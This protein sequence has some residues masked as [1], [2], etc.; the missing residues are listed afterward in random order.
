MKR[1]R[2]LLSVLLA[3]VM[4]LPCFAMPIWAEEPAPIVNLLDTTG[5]VLGNVPKK[6]TSAARANASYCSSGVFTVSPGQTVTVGPVMVDQGYVLRTYKSDGEVLSD[7][8]PASAVSVETIFN[9]VAILTFTVP[10]NAVKAAIVTSR[11]FYDCALVTVDRTYTKAEYLAYMAEKGVNLDFL[12][13]AVD[14]TEA[15]VNLF[16][17]SENT[18]M[19]NMSAGTGKT[20]YRYRSCPFI[21]VTEGD[22]I[23]YA[24]ASNAQQYHIS[25]MTSGG[26][27]ANL[28]SPK[29][30]VEDLG[31]EFGIYAYRVGPDITKVSVV[32]GTPTYDDGITLVTK[33]QPFTAERY[34]EMFN[35]DFSEDTADKSSPLYGLSGL[36]MGDSISF[37]HSDILSYLDDPACGKAWAGRIAAA[38]GLRAT[39]A[40]VIGATV[41]YGSN[42]VADQYAD[43]VGKSFDLIVM[44]GGANDALK[45]TAVGTPL[46][47]GASAEELEA[48]TDTYIGGLQWLFHNMKE[49]FPKAE[50][51]FIANH[52]LDGNEYAGR[53]DM[54]AYFDA[55]E[56]LCETYGVHFIDLYNNDELN[57]RLETTTTKYLPDTTHLV[58]A[59]Y[60]IL[61]PYILEELEAEMAS[62]AKHVLYEEDFDDVS[63][64]VDLDGGNN[65]TGPAAGWIWARKSLA[66]SAYIENGRLYFSGKAY[67]VLYR[68]GGETWGNYTLEA[69]FCYTEGTV[70]W[71]GM[72]YNVQSATKFQKGSINPDGKYYLNGYDGGW[73][74]DKKNVNKGFTLAENIPGIGDPFRM[75]I[76][77]FNK[78]ATFYYALLNEDGTMKTDWTTL[79]TINNIPAASQTGSIGF[80]SCK[81]NLGSFWVD[82]I[83]CYSNNLVS[84]TEDFDSYG[85]VT[86]EPDTTNTSIGVNYVKNSADSFVGK[87]E[88]KDGAL[89]L[90]GGTKHL[91][92]FLFTMGKNW[93]NYVLES[94]FTYLD[95]I[96]GSNNSGWAGILFRATDT[97]TFYKC[98]VNKTGSAKMN[99]KNGSTSWYL[100]G[101]ERRNASYGKDIAVGETIR[102]RFVV[103][104]K[105]FSM[106]VA[107]YVDGVLGEWVHV[108]TLEGD[109]LITD[110]HLK[111]T[112]GLVVGGSN[113]AKACNVCIDNV[114]VSRI[115]DADRY[116]T[117]TTNVA[118]IYE[119][120]SGVVNPPV[121][122]EELTDT[123]PSTSGERA[124]VVMMNVD[125]SLN[126]L[127]AD[128]AVLTT[129]SDFIDTYRKVLIPAF[130]IDSEAEAD[131][132]AAL[133][134]EKNLIDCYV[135]AESANAALVRRVRMANDTTKL[136]SGAV[137]FDDLNTLAARQN[138]RATVSDNMAY[139]AISRAPLSEEAAH[140]FN[141]RQIAAW[142]YASDAAG[143]YKGIANGYHG[144]VSTDV[145]TVY[146]VY[147]SITETTVSGKPIIIAHR[148]NN[149]NSEV[150][151]PENTLIGFRS[152]KETYGADAVELD[153]GLT[154]DG[155]VVLMHDNTVDRT[156]NGTGTVASLTL[157]EIKALTVDYVE[158]KETTV[159]TFEEALL[160]AKE[161]GI[162]L[163]CHTKS[164][165]DAN[166]AAFSYLVEKH[167]AWDYVVLFA[168]NRTIYNSNNESVT[169][170]EAYGFSD[171]AVVTDG[172]VFTAGDQEILSNYTTT[173][174]EGVEAMRNCLVPY[175][176]QP[177]F[178][179]YNNQGWMWNKETF[180]YQLS[181]RGF[182]NIH[183]ITKG[184]AELDSTALYESG[185]VGWLNDTLHLCDDYH[186][187]FDLSGEKLTLAV[188]ETLDLSKTLKMIVGTIP[189]DCGFIQISGPTLES[190]AG[191]YTL[192]GEGSVTVVY[193]ADRTADGG[194]TYRVYSEPVTIT[195][196]CEDHVYS[197]VCDTTCNVTGCGYERTAPHDFSAFDRNGE[198]HWKK[199]ALCGTA[200]ESTKADHVYDNACDTICNDE[201]C[202]YE[203]EITHD[204]SVTDHNDVQH[205]KKCSVCG[206]EQEGSRA[207]H[208]YDGAGD[209]ECDC[210]Y[211][212][213]C[214]SH[215][216]TV[217]DNDGTHHWL[218]CSICGVRNESSVAEHNYSTNKSNET[219]H[220]KVCPFCLLVE[221]GSAEN[222]VYESVCDPTCDCGNTRTIVHDYCVKG[223]DATHHWEACLL[224]G[225]VDETAKETHVFG[226]WVV[227]GD[228]R[229]RS[230]ACGYSESEKIPVATPDDTTDVPGSDTPVDPGDDTTAPDGDDTTADLGDDTTEPDDDDTTA[231]VVTDGDGTDADTDDEDSGCGSV[232][233]GATALVALALILPAAVAVR[234]KDEE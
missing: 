95:A 223:S 46:A 22:I 25:V 178:Y 139:V 134:A 163:Y 81:D 85:D 122:V 226:E 45:E 217:V 61:T 36:F 52:K 169:S 206:L 135:I 62:Y 2:K 23:Y 166:I 108:I 175:N 162:V 150:K 204:F 28:E 214:S 13:P 170:S 142:S 138:A 58:S 30:L 215:E 27:G 173:Y 87:A 225:A 35:I 68:D 86:I 96:E 70:G 126:V 154:K 219:Q 77:V 82:N 200:D 5:F 103:N 188:G 183:S 53:R 186:Y 88:V 181:A 119:P 171:Q 222:H 165:T 195:F 158:G 109:E 33:N 91:D 198:Q 196:D 125:A 210:G 39:N 107:P 18:I 11:M 105:I 78:S 112:I 161:L 21:D 136:I 17:V 8:A 231:D 137:I 79:V 187:G 29:L 189:V 227:T 104:E 192:S 130:V 98:I 44:H 180:Y 75:K 97:Q 65:L 76:T 172:I 211:S 93:T 31:R 147:E 9:N 100:D 115:S 67:D 203:R 149:A 57:A 59:G 69:D 90:T 72:L 113:T 141:L 197:D 60:D 209:S 118:E 71:G 229:T 101:D 80:M 111:G 51:F 26:S 92:A 10:T 49:E 47:I 228:T 201:T 131:A 213:T 114:T 157:E 63:D 185:A 205:W 174:L 66:G 199:C 218:E 37:G 83:R 102:Y 89:Y 73:V 4:L 34:R 167:E 224:C 153:F 145:A 128:G 190:M 207:S 182:V 127:K 202:G 155:Y 234:K 54:S 194:S 144:I 110:N 24:A 42:W 40:S 220:W 20:N 208:I 116:Y 124:A 232:I 48:A 164:N 129:V 176:Y 156:T 140:Y 148:G 216:F 191:G 117:D 146:D 74:N 55:A 221:E 132:L 184:Q 121:V 120:E 84:Y 133:I 233:G 50:L 56:A 94:D 3:I 143:V 7:I 179:P 19:G 43:H 177:L 99:C 230:C 38:T 14:T 12:S 159:P 15:L 1:T 16:P 41:A 160:L 106:Y 64:R 212:S 151:Y 193:Y 168:A 32:L 6:A 152:A 123:L